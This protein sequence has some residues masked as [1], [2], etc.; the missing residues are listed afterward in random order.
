MNSIRADLSKFYDFK[1]LMEVGYFWRDELGIEIEIKL[2][3][4]SKINKD[5]K[6]F[7]NIYLK[8]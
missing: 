7:I 2:K 3:H 1:N 5:F 4:K 6:N 8:N